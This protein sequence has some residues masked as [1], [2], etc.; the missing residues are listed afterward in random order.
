MG[1]NLYPARAGEV[2]RAYVLQRRSGIRIGASLGTI[3][4]ERVFDGWMMLLLGMAALLAFPLPGLLRPAVI[5]SSLLLGGAL[6]L[7]VGIAH[8]AERLRTVLERMARR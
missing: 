8:A 5:G 3:V 1:N 2:L 4:V 7:L 6:A